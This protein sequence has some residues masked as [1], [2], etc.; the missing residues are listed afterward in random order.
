MW[1]ME[2]RTKSSTWRELKTVSKVLESL[3][4]DLKGKM[5]KLYTDNQNVVK[6][7]KK[8]SMK[9]ELQNICIFFIYVYHIIFC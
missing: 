3:Y 7:V 8:G 9:P 4:D 2:N 1:D 6:I 5:V